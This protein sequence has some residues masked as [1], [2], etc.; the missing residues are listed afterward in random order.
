MLST[1]WEEGRCN[2]AV[3]AQGSRSIEQL[4][5]PLSLSCFHSGF[6]FCFYELCSS[7]SMLALKQCFCTAPSAF[8]SV[9]IKILK[10]V[11]AFTTIKMLI[12][13]SGNNWR[14]SDAIKSSC[15]RPVAPL[16][17]CS[18]DYVHE[19]HVTP[20]FIFQDQKCDVHLIF[21]FHDISP[22]HW[23]P[24]REEAQHVI[25]WQEVRETASYYLLF[26][27]CCHCSHI[28][29]GNESAQNNLSSK[30]LQ[31]KR[32]ITVRWYDRS[33]PFPATNLTAD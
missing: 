10:A 6:L 13:V 18:S 20:P 21:L 9:L 24:D 29:D 30:L 14:I 22:S 25:Q 16:W 11:A 5:C 8:A 31:V 33:F 32:N 7:F 17:D 1:G 2:S 28:Q 26:A 23:H 15:L 4:C 3:R 12:C 19:Q 27:K